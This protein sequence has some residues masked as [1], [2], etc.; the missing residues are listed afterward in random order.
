MAMTSTSC[1]EVVTDNCQNYPVGGV[2][3]CSSFLAPLPFPR[4][5]LIYSYGFLGILKQWSAPCMDRNRPLPI[6]HIGAFSCWDAYG[7]FR[8]MTTLCS[9]SP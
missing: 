1:M 4:M 6:F 9:K 2:L 7:S 8:P 5:F 3:L